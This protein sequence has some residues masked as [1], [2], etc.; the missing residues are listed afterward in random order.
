MGIQQS[1]A[2][3]TVAV[4]AA[5]VVV[6]ASEETVAQGGTCP[7]G[8]SSDSHFFCIRGRCVTDSTPGHSRDNTEFLKQRFCYGVEAESEAQGEVS[9]L[10]N[11]I[12]KSHK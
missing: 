5:A 12:K 9:F 7:A 4:V 1:P 6:V 2:H 3:L 10:N 11:Q 8:W